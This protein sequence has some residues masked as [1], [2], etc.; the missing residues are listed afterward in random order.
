MNIS[1]VCSKYSNSDEYHSSK[2]FDSELSNVDV[3]EG[4]CM[5]S[6]IHEKKQEK[7]KK[8][9]SKFSFFWSSQR[10]VS[11]NA[12]FHVE[13]RKSSSFIRKMKI[14]FLT[15]EAGASLELIFTLTYYWYTMLHVLHSVGSE[16]FS[17][18]ESEEK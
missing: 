12:V 2:E 3:H 6:P 11:N 15:N 16:E 4:V 5:P 9:K 18:C 8:K 13:V 14:T 7:K 10:K 17:H 1:T